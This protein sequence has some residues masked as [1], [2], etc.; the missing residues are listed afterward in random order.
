MIC[1]FL[2]SAWM[3]VMTCSHIHTQIA[4]SLLPLTSLTLAGMSSVKNLICILWLEINFFLLP[5]WYTSIFFQVSAALYSCIMLSG[6]DVHHRTGVLIWCMALLCSG[7]C[8]Q[9]DFQWLLTAYDWFNP[10]CCSCAWEDVTQNCTF[11]SFC[12]VISFS[13]ESQWSGQDVTFTLKG[14]L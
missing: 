8:K 3:R 12:V 14:S 11:I 13:T 1:Q 5:P 2:K 6:E 4:G 7:K 9:C 10:G